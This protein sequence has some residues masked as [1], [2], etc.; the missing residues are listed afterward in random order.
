MPRRFYSVE[1][2]AR[3][4]TNVLLRGPLLARAYAGG[5]DRRLRERVMVA[6]SQVNACS[7]CTRLHQSWARRAG[8]SLTELDALRVGDLKTLDPRSRAAVSYAVAR[9]ERRFAEPVPPDVQQSAREHLSAGELDQVDAV[10]RAMALANLSLSTL[11]ER[12]PTPR[13]GAGRHPVF[14]RVWSHTSGKVGSAGERSELLAGLSGRVLEVGAGDGRNFAHYPQGVTEVLAVEPE[15]Y[16]RRL[17]YR[18]ALEAPVQITVVD[19][20][21][22]SLPHEDGA[23]DSVVTSLV[24]CSVADQETALAELHR[25]LVPG[26]ELR[27]FEHVIAEGGLGQAV[28]ASLDRSGIWPQLGAGCH[29]ARDTVAAIADAGFHVEQVRRFKSGPGPVGPPFV[30][31][32]ARRQPAPQPMFALTQPRHA[33]SHTNVDLDSAG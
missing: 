32:I 14:A 33:N 12:K 22:E 29:L 30:L 7:E 15:P 10:A 25:V 13:T 16:L 20:T 3:D 6:V 26:G 11:I 31:G 18:A 1:E 9:A 5:L 4:F 24:L 28:Q 8:V 19:G 23:F 27:F 17:A 21:A 2:A